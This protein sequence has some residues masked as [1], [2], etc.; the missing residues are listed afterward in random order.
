MPNMHDDY[1]LANKTVLESFFNDEATKSEAEAKT[2]AEKFHGTVEYSKTESWGETI[3]NL[4]FGTGTE[5]FNMSLT[6]PEAKALFNKLYEHRS[7]FLR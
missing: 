1:H 7:D 3:F 2:A 6:K 4:D 5:N